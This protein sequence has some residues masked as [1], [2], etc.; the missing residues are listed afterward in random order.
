MTIRAALV[1]LLAAI[2]LSSQAQ[3]SSCQTAV[4]YI[5][6]YCMILSPASAGP[7]AR[8]Y[9]FTSPLDSVYFNFVSFVPQGTCADAL[10]WYELYDSTCTLITSDTIGAFGGLTPGGSYTMCY[11]IQCP[12]DGVVNLICTS[13]TAALPVELLYFTARPG[14]SGVDLVWATGSERNCMG[15]VVERSTDLSTWLDIGFLSGNT[16]STSTNNYT[17][18]DSKPI[19]GVNYYRL[20]QIDWDGNYETFQA[21]AIMWGDDQINSPFRLYNVL[22]QSIKLR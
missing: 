13:E 1:V 20:R 9:T 18:P 19:N 4:P 5:D 8:C 15:F 16:N 22:G 10:S 11:N 3:N 6:N 17:L 14:L 21:I 7:I 12:T 2:G